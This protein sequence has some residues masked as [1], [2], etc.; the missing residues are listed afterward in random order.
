[1]KENANFFSWTNNSSV[2]WRYLFIWIRLIFQISQYNTCFQTKIGSSYSTWENIISGDPYGSI[3]G[4]LLF[5]IFLCDLFLEHEHCCYVNYADDTNPYIVANNTAEVLKKLTN[6]TQ[7]LF[8]WFANKGKTWKMS[9]FAE[10]TR[11]CYHP[12]IKYDNKLF[13]I[14]KVVRYSVWEQTEVWQV[15]WEYLSKN[16]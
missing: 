2:Q 3:L 16:K 1:M 11:G 10:H 8:T 9:P 15:R 4:P 14:K 12:N 13:K 6:I 7:R 5:N